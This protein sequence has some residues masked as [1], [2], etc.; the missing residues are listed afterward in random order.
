MVVFESKEQYEKETN[1]RKPRLCN[2]ISFDYK[3]VDQSEKNISEMKNQPAVSLEMCAS[4]IGNT[5]LVL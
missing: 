2:L 5:S 4:R 3:F 1:Y